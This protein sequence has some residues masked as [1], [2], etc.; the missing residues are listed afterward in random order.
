VKTVHYTPREEDAF[1]LCFDRDTRN[2][3]PQLAFVG[4]SGGILFEIN[5]AGL[6]GDAIDPSRK[7][8]VV[9]G[10]SVVF[11]A[12]RGWPCLLDG[13]APGWQ[14]LNGGIVGDPFNNILR[15]AREFNRCYA[16]ALNLVMPGWHPLNENEHLGAALTDF[17]RE[18]PNTVLLTMPTA[19]NRQLVE[20]DLSPYFTDR[21]GKNAFTFLGEIPYSREL[22][23]SLFDHILERN[24]IVREVATQRGL[25]PVDLH[26]EFDT[27]RTGGFRRDFHDVIHPRPNTYARIAQAV[28][29][30][31]RDLLNRGG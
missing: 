14:F 25:R 26:A 6:K 13:L 23:A 16:V 19:M 5:E 4:R 29:K 21:I 2:L 9:W 17:V 27:E 24:A 18:V 3:R 20:R 10:D 1:G 22:Q 8:A 12:G 31:I 11:G 15:R 28:H 7:L 30:A